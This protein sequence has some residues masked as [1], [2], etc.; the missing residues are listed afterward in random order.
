[1][2]VFVP[3]SAIA[4]SGQLTALIGR[5]GKGKSTLLRCMAGLQKVLGGTI[6]VDGINIDKI[7][8][9]KLASI[10]SY[11]STDNVKVGN[12]RVFDL[13]AL[14]RYPHLGLLGKLSDADK[15]VVER[16]LQ[17][18]GMLDS[19]RKYLYQLSD[20]ERQRIIIAR[21]LAQDTAVIILDEPTAFLDVPNR[22]EILALLRKLAQENSKTIVFSTHDIALS[23]Q[24]AQ[25][26]W[27]MGGN[28]FYQHADKN[29]I[30]AEFAMQTW[31]LC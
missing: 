27:L 24:I 13:V 15:S 16:S 3:F 21:A 6:F 12:L 8:R 10:V 17:M 1:M 29:I 4:H 26:I 23:Q 30:E 7:S 14:G 28:N 20:G 25:Q 2:P 18:V 11:V 19:A 22:C 31:N 5:N 9:R